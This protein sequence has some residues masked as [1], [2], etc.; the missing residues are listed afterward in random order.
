VKTEKKHT[1]KN[2]IHQEK[3]QAEKSQAAGKP[4]K[5]KPDTDEDREDRF[6]PKQ[7]FET[8]ADLCKKRWDLRLRGPFLVLK[9]F[10]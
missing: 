10:P 2:R 8:L 9:E 3:S 7:L 5:I 1:P 4:A 6:G